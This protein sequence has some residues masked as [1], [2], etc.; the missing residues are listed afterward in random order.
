MYVTHQSRERERRYTCMTHYYVTCSVY[1][2]YYIYVCI[3][4]NVQYIII[5]KE[6]G[7]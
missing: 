2:I 3:S 1:F 7:L 5:S 4:E 6:H